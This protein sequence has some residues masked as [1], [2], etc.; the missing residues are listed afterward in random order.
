MI[1]LSD[2]N[3]LQGIV[4][5]IVDAVHPQRVILFGSRATGKAR[6]GSDYDFLVV[7]NA[8]KNERN[9]SRRIYKA[10]FERKI[11][12]AVDIVVVDQKKLRKHQE[13]PYLIYSWALKEGQVL[14]G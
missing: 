1:K 3:K 10:L 2:Q 7:K 6:K 11:P 8:V 12:L 4:S 13:N 9:I 14:Y 5:T